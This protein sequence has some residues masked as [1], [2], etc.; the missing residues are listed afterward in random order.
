MHTRRST[1]RSSRFFLG[2]REG[3][4][5]E[6]LRRIRQANVAR[7]ASQLDQKSAQIR[8]YAPPRGPVSS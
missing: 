7:F 5:R 2:P 1:G 8:Q 4:H 6:V 3:D